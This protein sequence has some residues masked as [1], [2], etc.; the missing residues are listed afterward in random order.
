MKQTGSAIIFIVLLIIIAVFSFL[1]LIRPFKI[2]DNAV[3]PF[4]GGEIVLAEKVSYMFSQPKI[5]DRVLFI[6]KDRGDMEYVGI[7]KDITEEG[8]IK[9]FSIVS[10]GTGQPW[11][12]TKDKIVWKVYFPA[13]SREEIIT[14]LPSP[15]PSTIDNSQESTTFAETANWKTYSSSDGVYTFKYPSQWYIEEVGDNDINFFKSGVTPIHT[16][17]HNF[18]NETFRIEDYTTEKFDDIENSVK[19]ADGSPV[20]QAEI[21]ISG[22]RV[23]KYVSG[24][25]VHIFLT[26]LQ[27]GPDR[28]LHLIIADES[29]PLLLDQILSTFKFIN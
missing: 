15:S 5:G 29:D 7:I 11:L 19:N 20:F 4:K 6:P 14:N 27:N 16:N 23:L 2:P 21:N 1:F 28:V 18:G 25:A 12:V 8:N 3:K 17:N 26:H 9:T 13:V 24:K 22:K 10:T